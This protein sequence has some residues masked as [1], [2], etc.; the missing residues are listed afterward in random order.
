MT[1]TAELLDIN[2]V[3]TQV[4]T[5]DAFKNRVSGALNLETALVEGFEIGPVARVL[6]ERDSAEPNSAQN[7]VLQRNTQRFG[8]LIGVRNVSDARG[9]AAHD[10]LRELRM[11]LMQ[12]LL[13]WKPATGFKPVTY[14]SGRLV[15]IRNR[16]LW[17]S[18]LFQ[19]SSHIRKV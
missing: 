15:L 6:P 11:A 8:I 16:V 5:I 10:A 1:V 7:A 19:T 12:K 4:K 14:V 9:A 13:G 17:W 18:D 3:L 2:L